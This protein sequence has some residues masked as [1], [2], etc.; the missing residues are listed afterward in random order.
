MKTHELTRNVVSVIW[1]DFVDRI[2][3]FRLL[4]DPPLR[5]VDNSNILTQ[6]VS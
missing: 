6:T 1:H 4:A 3:V 2:P 5:P